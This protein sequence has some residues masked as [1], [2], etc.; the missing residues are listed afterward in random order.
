MKNI[1]LRKIAAMLLSVIMVVTALTTGVFAMGDDVDINI[2]DSGNASTKMVSGKQLIEKELATYEGVTV[3]GNAATLNADAAS[4]EFTVNGRDAV[5]LNLTTDAETSVT[6]KLYV[7][8]E[9]VKDIVLTTGTK[10]VTLASGLITGK[11]TFKLVRVSPAAAGNVAINYVSVVGG[12]VLEV[13][14]G[15]PGDLNSDEVVDI[16]DVVLLAQHVAGWTVEF[17]MDVANVN[18]QDGIDIDD[19]VLLAQHVAGW[20]VTLN[21]A[22]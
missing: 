19:V 10:E 8:G 22:A 17:N 1:N 5:K 3:A 13:P 12:D 11:Y 2:G 4:I 18:G 9:E 16:D 6:L 15:M 14:K 7:D 20:D 21:G